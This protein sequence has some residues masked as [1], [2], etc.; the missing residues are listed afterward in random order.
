MK[1]ISGNFTE[2]NKVTVEIDGKYITRTVRYN[3]DC[4]LYIVYQNKK[5][6]EYEFEFIKWNET[7][8]ELEE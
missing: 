8:L 7:V 5:Y 2:N 6:F 3:S 4:G 1:V